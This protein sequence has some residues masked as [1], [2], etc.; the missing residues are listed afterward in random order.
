MSLSNKALLASLTISQW[1]GRKHDKNATGTVETMY[2]TVGKVGNYSKKLLPG[3]TELDDIQKHAQQLRMFFYEQTL[4]WCADGSRILSSKNYIDFTNEFRSKKSAFER[5]VSDFIYA[6]PR[7][8]QEAKVKLGDLFRE[9]DYPTTDMLRGAF[10]CEITF[11]PIPDVADFRVEILD[12]ERDSFLTR[13]T[14][15][16]TA[17][18]RDCWHR[19]HDV[20]AK[21]AAKLQSPETIFRDSLISNI[22][23]MCA[24]LPKLNVNDDTTLETMRQSVESLVAS[25]NP[26]ACRANEIIR[27]DAATKLDEITAKMSA[28]M[29]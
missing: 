4:P 6:Y 1:A 20:V 23:E 14:E 3:A 21:A 5:A 13:M 15:V 2:S 12:S 28:F 27:S 10:N 11:M 17:A 29:S 26:E 7:L 18:T 8:L 24:L 22:S 19:L 9:T 25:I 16:E